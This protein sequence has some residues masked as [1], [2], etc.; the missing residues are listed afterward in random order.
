MNKENHEFDQALFRKWQMESEHNSQQLKTEQM[1][2]LLKNVSGDFS[3]SLKRTIRM[4][5]VLKAVLMAGFIIITILNPDSLLVIST[6][7]LFI[8]AGIFG[9]LTGRR[10]VKK[11]KSIQL[12]DL[13]ISQTVRRELKFYRSILI[14]YPIM[15]SI[16]VAMF[17]VLGS[18]IYHF[19]TYGSIQPFR[20]GTDV[21]V[22]IGLMMI[23][24]LFSLGV[25]FPFFRAK[26]NNLEMLVNDLANEDDFRRKE[27]EIRVGKKM[28]QT[29]L[30]MIALL[31]IIA[32][33]LILTL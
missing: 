7:V 13:D 15:M 31:G 2:N 28:K 11:M 5:M 23:G 27:Q 24:I 12:M 14:R 1:E 30:L 17:Y 6:S 10:L 4:D 8:L 22:L 25:N 29:I 21:V 18:M 16:S 19:V 3:V 9:L 26:I 32:L 20:D 33:I